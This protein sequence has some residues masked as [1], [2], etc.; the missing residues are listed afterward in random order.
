MCRSGVTKWRGTEVAQPEDPEI[1]LIKNGED[2]ERQSLGL[3]DAETTRLQN[4]V[5]ADINTQNRFKALSDKITEETAALTVLQDRLREGSSP[6]GGEI[7][8]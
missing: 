5:N 8:S 1:P 2:F 7:V 4:L 3:L 6:V